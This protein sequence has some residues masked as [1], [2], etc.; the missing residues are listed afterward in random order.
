MKRHR[1]LFTAILAAILVLAVTGPARAQNVV[2]IDTVPAWINPDSRNSLSSAWGDLDNDGDLDMVVGTLEQGIHV[3]TNVDGNFPRFIDIGDDA[4]SNPTILSIVAEDNRP[5]FVSSSLGENNRPANHGNAA[6]A[7][8]DLNGDGLL[9]LVVANG[10]PGFWTR[11]QPNQVYL[12][13]TRIGGPISLKPAEVTW[14]NWPANFSSTA[15]T[16]DVALADI[17]RDGRLDMVFADRG[18]VRVYYNATAPGD[19]ALVMNMMGHDDSCESS[20][21]P[22]KLFD[23]GDPYLFLTE[24]LLD[25]LTGAPIVIASAALARVAEMVSDDRFGIEPDATVQ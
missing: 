23:Y 3:W 6:V 1:I 12:N 10:R 21:L 2:P 20:P 16:S 5:A 7:I 13:H 4:R 17:D 9:D 24:E 11:E 14:N 8:G 15:A 19:D 22:F 18:W 25:E